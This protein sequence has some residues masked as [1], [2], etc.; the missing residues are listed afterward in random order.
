[1]PKECAQALAAAKNLSWPETCFD[2]INE[3]A[4]LV[5]GYKFK[6]AL[7]AVASLKNTLA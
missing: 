7:A 2:K 6:D 1:M 4:G 5:A 3:L